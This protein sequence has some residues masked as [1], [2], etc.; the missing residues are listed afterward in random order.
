MRL[1]SSVRHKMATGLY[2]P[3]GVEMDY[4]RTGPVTRGNCLKSG[5]WGFALD[6][7]LKTCTFKLYKKDDKIYNNNDNNDN[8]LMDDCMVPDL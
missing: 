7:R 8:N 6:T 2:A 4:E 3:R 1:N 5:K